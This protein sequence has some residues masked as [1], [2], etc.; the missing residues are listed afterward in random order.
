M[1]LIDIGQTL[2]ACHPSELYH[3]DEQFR[4]IPA[5]SVAVR[6][7]DCVPCDGDS[8][9]DASATQAVQQMLIDSGVGNADNIFLEARIEHT[10]LD[11]LWVDSL[12]VV[13]RLPTLNTFVHLLSVR[14]ELVKQQYGQLDDRASVVLRKMAADAGV[15][16]GGGSYGQ[17]VDTED[18]TI[19]LD[20]EIPDA[21]VDGKPD[22][23]VERSDTIAEV[24]VQANDGENTELATNS[25]EHGSPNL[26]EENWDDCN[27]P[28]YVPPVV[29]T[30]TMPV[31]TNDD[32]DES[33]KEFD[34]QFS[35][36]EI[37]A[38]V[39]FG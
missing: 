36:D 32:D 34:V 39:R 28:S 38:L 17:D 31:E 23:G 30:S 35:S 3:L 13:E 10:V 9:W 37:F 16:M 18:Q 6:I 7:A 12:R 26:D 25:E 19:E 1:L 29:A 5:Q 14:N 21:E 4:S 15:E 27:F 20:E 24:E 11:T 33:E 8:E 22:G 2:S